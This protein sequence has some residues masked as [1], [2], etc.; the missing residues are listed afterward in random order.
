MW[1]RREGGKMEGEKGPRRRAG[2]WV[3]MS[4]NKSRGHEFAQARQ[5]SNTW[6]KIIRSPRHGTDRHFANLLRQLPHSSV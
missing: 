3:L 2:L 5:P 6:E 1:G 4:L